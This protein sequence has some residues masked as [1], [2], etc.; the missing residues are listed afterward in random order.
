MTA[1]GA[2]GVG[3]RAE[4]EVRE[5]E[6]GGVHPAGWASSPAGIPQGTSAEEQAECGGPDVTCYEGC[7]THA[8]GLHPQ[9]SSLAL[10]LL[11]PGP[12]IS[13]PGH[14]GSHTKA[15]RGSDTGLKG[16]RRESWASDFH[17][18]HT[19]NMPTGIGLAFY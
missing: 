16:V 1:L 7:G 6:E 12:L 19:P 15:P 3:S 17:P 4:S 8:S 11:L 2:A 13:A 10:F 14:T 5:S 9:G 18:A